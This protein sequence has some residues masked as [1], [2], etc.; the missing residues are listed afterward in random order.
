MRNMKKI[1]LDFDSVL[2]DTMVT[3]VIKYNEEHNTDFT[4]DHIESWS[5][6][7]QKEFGFD[8][9]YAY[10][11]FRKS[12]ADWKNLP[13][14]EPDLDKRITELSEFGQV[15]IVT[16]VEKDYFGNVK[17]WIDEQNI[18]VND[19]ISSEGKNKIKD[20]DYNL[21]IDDDPLLAK[22]AHFKNKNCFVYHQKWNKEVE[23]SNFVTR[24][25]N[26]T[27]AIENI[28]KKGL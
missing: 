2:S 18:S 1:A 19:I 17:N 27:N 26:L 16:N 7:K 25:N 28:S 14:T 24:I 23:E 15:D 20:F 12:W 5:F 21:Y 3:W 10:T 4:K 9:S 11:F 8:M 22:D 6:W 13:P